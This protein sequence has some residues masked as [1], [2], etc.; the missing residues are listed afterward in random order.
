MYPT[1]MEVNGRIY[2]I[3]TDYRVAL[4]CLKA[5]DDD[6]I[7]GYEKF[8][9]VESLLLGVNVLRQDELALKPKIMKYLRCGRDIN[10]N[11]SEVD[12]DYIQD[13]TIIRT[14]I[15]QCYNNLDIGKI[16]YLHWYEYNEL[17]E[18]LTT[19]TLLNKIRE[20]RT[21]DVSK[22]TDLKRKKEIENA[23]KRVALKKKVSLTDEQ[24]SKREQFLKLAKINVKG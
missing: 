11:T 19:E 8:I 24:K 23:K 14:S 10:V 15:R 2:D 9:A 21:Y 5:I 18:G 17:I 13:E 6:T 20:L 4:A 1:K 22:E 16:D 7:S 12:M 3:N